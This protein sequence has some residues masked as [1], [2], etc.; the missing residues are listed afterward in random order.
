MHLL[1]VE[2]DASAALAGMRVWDPLLLHAWQL[3]MVAE[4]HKARCW[5]GGVC[6]GEFCSPVAV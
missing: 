5:N 4:Q 2:V 6:L 3:S 1:H